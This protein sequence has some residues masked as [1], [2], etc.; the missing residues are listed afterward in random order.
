MGPRWKLLVPHLWPRF[1]GE[2]VC[3]CPLEHGF[4]KFILQG[5]ILWSS[6]FG[7]QWIPGDLKYTRA[8]EKS[9]HLA[10]KK[11]FVFD[12]TLCPWHQRR[13]FRRHSVVRYPLCDSLAV[14][15]LTE[16][17]TVWP[18]AFHLWNGDSDMNA[19]PLA[20]SEQQSPCKGCGYWERSWTGNPCADECMIWP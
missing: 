2:M 17:V 1:S 18:L 19:T 13:H 4:Y 7:E 6:E 9:W 8:Y 20:W 3:S 10:R 16:S 12:L 5:A 11:P 15:L 14:W